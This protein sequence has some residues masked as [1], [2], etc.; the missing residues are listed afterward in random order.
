MDNSKKQIIE[1][2]RALS[3]ALSLLYKAEIGNCTLYTNK[4][5]EIEKL[6]RKNRVKT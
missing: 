2:K 5:S 4:I 1:L 3:L 6:A